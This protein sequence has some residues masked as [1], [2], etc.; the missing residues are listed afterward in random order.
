MNSDLLYLLPSEQ[1]AILFYDDVLSA[2]HRAL[3]EAR[4][5]KRKIMALHDS[6]AVAFLFCTFFSVT[7]IILEAIL[8]TSIVDFLIPLVVQFLI[9]SV[10]SFYQAPKYYTYQIEDLVTSSAAAN[11]TLI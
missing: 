9:F 6:L 8:S 5:S 2:I 10:F 3:Y 7:P 1:S 4:T 11:K